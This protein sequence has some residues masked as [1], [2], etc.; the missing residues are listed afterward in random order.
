MDYPKLSSMTTDEIDAMRADIARSEEAQVWI[1]WIAAFATLCGGMAYPGFRSS[2]NTVYL[3]VLVCGIPVAVAGFVYAGVVRARA[4][5][6]FAACE[7]D[8]WLLEHVTDSQTAA[9]CTLHMVDVYPACRRLKNAVLACGRGL[10]H[11][12][13]C[14]M[15]TIADDAAHVK[16]LT[17]AQVLRRKLRTVS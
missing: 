11:F 15:R 17:L 16:S 7:G 8:A 3:F 5:R 12:D 13:M 4:N 6:Q 1:C 9:T 14:Q 2:G 10:Y